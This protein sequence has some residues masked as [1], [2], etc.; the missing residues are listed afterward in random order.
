MG[1]LKK[2]R[3]L[4]WEKID[5]TNKNS[6]VRKELRKID[7]HVFQPT[8]DFLGAAAVSPIVTAYIEYLEG[9]A[10]GK[11]K[12]LP[13]WLKL[14]LHE[15][16]SYDIDLSRVSYAEGINTLQDN[17]AITFGYNIHFPQAINLDRTSPSRDDV[18]WILHELEHCVQ[19]RKL[20]GV[21]PFLAKYIINTAGSS[22]GAVSAGSWEKFIIKTHNGMQIEKDA[23]NKAD[24]ILE[25]VMA[26][27]D[28]LALG[29][30]TVLARNLGARIDC[31]NQTIYEG[32]Y[33][34]SADGRHQFILQGDGN[35]VLYGPSHT[36]M[37][38]SSTDGVGRPPYRIVAQ[39]DRNVVQYDRDNKAIW[40]T[41][42]RE[43]GHTGCRLLLQDDG[44]LVLYQPRAEGSGLVAIWN[45]H[46]ST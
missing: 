19:Y 5:P 2:I 23:S 11:Y 42:T 30:P 17:N 22:I 40:R 10:K 26:E 14:V 4:P 33:L 39:D 6:E 21:G 18:W 31:T 16:G 8:W 13:Q 45:T 41:D 35:V 12:P 25:T 29:R 3:D 36:V 20:G 38:S 37:W 43:V 1:W 28:Q 32:D 44:N 15:L 9:Q 27:L 24:S 7:E 34:E 46:T